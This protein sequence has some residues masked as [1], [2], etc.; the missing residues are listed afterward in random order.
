MTQYVENLGESVGVEYQGIKVVEESNPYATSDALFIGCFKRGRMDKP[1][2]ITSE[3]I[4]QKLGYDPNN[5]DYIAVKEALD[6]GVSSVRVL[7]IAPSH[8]ACCTKNVEM[9]CVNPEKLITINC[10]C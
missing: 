6:E 3:N 1:M 4:R 5:I 10:G 9:E 2:T 7:R 8:G